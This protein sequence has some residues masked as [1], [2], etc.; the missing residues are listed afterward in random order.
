MNQLNSDVE[1]RLIKLA[2][3]LVDQ[4]RARIV[5]PPQQAASGFWFGGGNMIEAADGSLLLV[6][7][8]RNHGD[9]RT[10]LGLGERGLELAIFRSTDHGDSFTKTLS[11]AK[12]KLDIGELKVLSIEGSALKTTSSGV[13]LFI[14]TEK[15]GIPYPDEFATF[16]KPGTGVW[17]VDHL[18]ATSVE[19]LATATIATICQSPDPAVI[20]MK[21]PTV[22][23]ASNG[24]TVLMFCTHPFCWSSSNTA[25]AVRAADQAEFAT[26]NFGSFPRGPAWDVAITRGTAI[27]NVPRIGP[28]QERQ[29]S[30]LFYDGGESLRN[31]EEHETAVKR[32]RGYS[33]EEL[34]GVAY[35][36]DGVFRNI[37]RL[38]RAS[39]MFISPYGTGC[40]RYVDVLATSDAFYTTWQ[41]S[42]EDLSQPL[43]MTKVDRNEVASLLNSD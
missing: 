17:T 36:I 33:C 37:V 5:I 34:G 20:H 14:S 16:L 1:Q 30:L 23:A 10:G 28:F 12:S 40:S 24:D 2:A 6:G 29:V 8:Y 3:T 26:P 7:R 19:Q 25:F 31:L 4:R 21:D 13:E 22:Y 35:V 11:F 43:V 27:V 32:P 18:E 41:Q 42:Q 9:S 39:P 38:S 15:S